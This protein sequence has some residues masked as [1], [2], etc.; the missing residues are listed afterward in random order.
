MN[1]EQTEKLFEFVGRVDARLDIG[2]DKFDEINETLKDLRIYGEA[3]TLHLD[4]HRTVR[5][6]MGIMGGITTLLVGI[7]RYFK[8]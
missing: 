1:A 7:A 3:L 5:W 2:D 8:N 6:V 4:R